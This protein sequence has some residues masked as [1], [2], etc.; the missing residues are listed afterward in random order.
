[1]AGDP[2]GLVVTGEQCGVSHDEL[3]LHRGGLALA[4]AGET[5]DHDVGEDLL[6]AAPL[7]FP[8][9]HFRPCLV[10]QGLIAGSGFQ[11]GQEGRQ[12][13]HAV[14]SGLEVH[15]PGGHGLVVLLRCRFRICAMGQRLGFQ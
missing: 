7:G 8:E 2:R 12:I 10:G 1:M 11:R 6:G 14:L 5:F 9:G 4:A 3:D 15:M 13:G